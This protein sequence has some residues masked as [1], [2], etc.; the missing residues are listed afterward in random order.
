[1]SYIIETKGMIDHTGR[2]LG[3]WEP[4]EFGPD[5]GC[6]YRRVNAFKTIKKALAYLEFVSDYDYV[7]ARR[8]RGGR[9]LVI[10]GGL[11]R[12]RRVIG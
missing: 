10:N 8:S 1:M 6:E 7:F 11:I 4:C 3:A 12:I 5:T 2:A 9:V